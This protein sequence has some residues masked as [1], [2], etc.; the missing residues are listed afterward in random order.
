VF[1]YWHCKAFAFTH[2]L[3]DRMARNDRE[4]PGDDTRPIPDSDE[5]ENL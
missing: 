4:I 3:I 1:V 2:R 5:V